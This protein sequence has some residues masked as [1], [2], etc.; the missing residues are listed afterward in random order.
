M[1]RSGDVRQRQ[2]RALGDPTRHAIFQVVAASDAPVSVAELTQMSSLNHNA[3]RQ[4][5]GKLRDAGLVTEALL[6]HPGPGR[7]SL[8]YQAS[9]S[10]EVWLS[11]GPYEQL[12]LML[13]EM[14]RTG[15]TPRE[16]GVDVGAAVA[17]RVPTTDQSLS[18]LA[19]VLAAEMARRGF[20]PIRSEGDG[21]TEVVLHHCPFAAAAADD[22][23]VVCELHRGMAE[24]VVAAIS[25]GEVHVELTP[26]PPSHA[27]C[28]FRLSP[29]AVPDQG[30]PP[31]P[32]ARIRR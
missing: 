25:G 15:R 5:L 19:D 14:R 16:V 26:R 18:G 8:V 12:T 10:A 30:S 29:A 23:D 2:A 7:P 17:Q 21:G 4:H 32:R 27:G 13:L 6:S 3:V 1:N 20:E 24:G 28:R 9:L 22:P 31:S 11:V